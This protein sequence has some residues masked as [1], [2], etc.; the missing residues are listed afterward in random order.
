[1]KLTNNAATLACVLATALA[2]SVPASA[3]NLS[4]VVAPIIQMGGSAR[5]QIGHTVLAST[6]YNRLYAGG[7]YRVGCATPGAV[8]LEGQRF[9]T[10]ENIVGGRSLTVT[11]PEWHPAIVSMPGYYEAARGQR[12][13]CVYNWTSKAVEG[14]YSIGVGGISFQTGN[15]ERSDGASQPFMMQVPSLGDPNEGSTCIP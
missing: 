3:V 7:T 4:T 11:I 9:L 5:A 6:V 12:L 1:M 13:S 15:G 8:P 10:T 2:S 14:G